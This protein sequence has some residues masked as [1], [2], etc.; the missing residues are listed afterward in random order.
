MEFHNKFCCTCKKTTKMSKEGKDFLCPKCLK[1]GRE[2]EPRADLL[3]GGSEN[4]YII[5]D[6]EDY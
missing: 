1:V 3:K 5:F 6:C 4:P 2:I